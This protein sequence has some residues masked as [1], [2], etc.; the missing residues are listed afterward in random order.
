MPTRAQARQS[1]IRTLLHPGSVAII[2]ASARGGYS[3]RFVTSAVRCADMRVYPV[4]PRY[5]TVLGQP[6]Y[7]SMDALPETPDVV[8]VLVSGRHVPAALAD[9]A[10]HGVKAGVVVSSGFSELRTREGAENQGALAAVLE[11]VDMHVVGP[12][13]LGLGNPL[14]DIWLTGSRQV[15][16]GVRVPP[17]PIGIISQSGAVAFTTLLVRA[18]DLRIGLSTVVSTGNETS[19]DFNDFAEY[20]L[21]DEQTS[22]I[23]GYVEQIKDAVHFATIAEKAADLGKPIVL[24]K[25]G[26]S[27]QGARAAQA[28]TASLTGADRNFDGLFAKYGVVRVDDFEEVLQVANLM[29]NTPPPKVPGIGLISGSGGVNALTSDLLGRDGM[30][31]PALSAKTTTFLDETLGRFGSAG[32]PADFTDM[33]ATQEFGPMMKAMGEDPAVGT[34]VVASAGDRHHAEV[35]IKNREELDV[36]VTYLWTGSHHSKEGLATLQEAS[37]PVFYTPSALSRALRYRARHLATLERRQADTQVFRPELDQAAAIESLDRRLADHGPGRLS[38]HESK[39]I[40]RAYRIPVP[41]ERIVTSADDAAVAAAE[42]GYPVVMKIDSAAIPHKTEL[43]L[44]R[45]G[46]TD[47]PSV[48]EIFQQL[49]SRA[50][51]AAGPDAINGVSVQEYVTEAVEVLVGVSFDPQIGPLIVFGLGGT[52]VELHQNVVVVPAPLTLSDAHWMIERTSAQILLRG[53]RGAP[54]A[55]VQA[56]AETLI[57]VS[58]L[59]YDLRNTLTEFEINPLAVLPAGRGVRALDAFAVLASPLPGAATADADPEGEADPCETTV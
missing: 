17:G 54:A 57:T 5:S 11:T 4:N 10:A 23:A 45:L 31:L 33:I 25:V 19:L 51:K 50:E 59:A 56:L 30:E 53:F 52:S 1:A 46:V 12:N 9:A 40:V 29:A 27:A 22:V 15:A 24:A 41:G 8:A 16:D 43:G 18:A 6:C 34:L 7:P 26:R 36:G 20:L 3:T 42:I 58:S 32:N 28:H 2:G 14:R 37:V 38:E 47:E 35:V 55:D 21:N 44:V 49:L 48:R 13:C 39:E